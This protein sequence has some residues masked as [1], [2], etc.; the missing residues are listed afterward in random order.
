M[1]LHAAVDRVDQHLEFRRPVG[2]DRVVDPRPMVRDL[3]STNGTLLNGQQID[4]SPLVDGAVIQVG[5]TE[6]VFRSG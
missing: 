5:S 6:L 2:A 3:G 1:L 4:E